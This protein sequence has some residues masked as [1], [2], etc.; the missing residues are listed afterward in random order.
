MPGIY[1]IP[2]RCNGCKRR[3]SESLEGNEN[4]EVNVTSFTPE[5]YD[6]EVLY[7]KKPRAH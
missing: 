6:R 2:E 7:L 3:Y 1:L 5:I 4:S